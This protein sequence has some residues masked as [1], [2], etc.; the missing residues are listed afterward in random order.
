MQSKHEVKS[1]PR[2]GVIFECKVGDVVNCQ[3]Y[4]VKI[5]AKTNEFLSNAYYDCLC[6]N[7]LASIDKQ[8]TFAENQ[9]FPQTKEMLIEGVH[10]TKE[11][12]TLIYTELYHILRGQCCHQ[13]NCVN[14]AYGYVDNCEQ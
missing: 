1:C 14:C 3:C 13:K 11:N 5:Q 12:G 9:D 2:C 4:E 8:L 10:Y 7:C 6:K